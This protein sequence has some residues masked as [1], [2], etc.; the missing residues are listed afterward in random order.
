MIR[1]SF[2]IKKLRVVIVCL[3]LACQSN[4][5]QCTHTNLSKNFDFTTSLNRIQKDGKETSECDIIV[6]II[7]K[8]TKHKQIIRLHSDWMF[9]VDYSN[10]KYVRSYT[11]NFNHK[12][13]A[14][15]NDYGDIIVADYNFDGMEDVAIKIDSGGNAGPW[16][17][18]YLQDKAGEFKKNS[19][20]SEYVDLF[21]CEI[22]PKEKTLITRVHAN[23]VQLSET[24]YKLNITTG[25]WKKISHRL[26]GY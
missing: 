12:S 22:N 26:I 20:L 14:V 2:K 13:D 11:T 19:Y 16:Y 6:E 1:Y 18:Y 15:D 21:P 25:E 9:E 10:C 5:Q 4:G 3:L 23:A 7:N 17:A 8:S 24:I